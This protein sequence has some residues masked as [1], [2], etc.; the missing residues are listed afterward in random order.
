MHSSV[1]KYVVCCS[2]C[3]YKL[4]N[5]KDPLELPT[6]R[7]VLALLEKE[8][9]NYTGFASCPSCR[10]IRNLEVCFECNLPLCAPCIGKHFDAWKNDVNENCLAT[11]QKLESLKSKIDLI[12]PLITQNFESVEKIRTDVEEAF[13]ELQARLSREKTTILTTLNEVKEGSA[14][15]VNFKKDIASLIASFKMFRE[16]NEK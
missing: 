3:K 14:K 11:E 7:I 15:Y 1:E 12:S 5:V 4:E 6:S 16:S 2:Q 10:Q 8:S 9:L 13:G